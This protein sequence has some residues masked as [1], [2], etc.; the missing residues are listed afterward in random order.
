MIDQLLSQAKIAILQGDRA[1]ARIALRNAILKSPQDAQAW[2]LMAQVVE[3]RI[4]VVDCLQR[5]TQFDPDNQAAATALKVLMHKP[6]PTE[7][8]S[9]RLVP[10]I[11]DITVSEPI[12]LPAQT[13]DSLKRRTSINWSLVI[14]SV[15][16]FLVLVVS[17]LGPKIA[18]GDPLEENVILKFG[19]V[20][21][22]PPIPPFTYKEFPFG[23]DQ[24]GRDLYSRILWAVQPTIT[25][26]SA[27]ALVRL[28]LGTL[29]GL[30]AGW[31]RGLVGN[32]LDTAITAALAIP[33]FLV[34][35][36]AIAMLGAEMGL[37]AFIIGFSING[38][39]ETAR[40]VR[41]QTQAIKQQLYVE[42]AESIGASQIQILFSHVL[43]QI[44]PMVW[45]LLA[46]E[47]SNTLMVT[48]GLG[49]LGYYIGG[50]VWI[51]VGDFVSRRVS[52]MPELGQMLAT[53]WT[54]LTKPWPMVITGTIIFITVLGFN[55]FGEGL[56]L[57]LNPERGTSKRRFSIL[58][59]R[60]SWWLEEQAIR[61]FNLWARDNV[62]FLT[63]IVSL[64][65]LICGSFYLWRTQFSSNTVV[66]DDVIVVPG[67]H[68]WGSE[69]GD[70][71]GTYW[72]GSPGPTHP[73]VQW[74]LQM[75][76]GF[77]GGPVVAADH[78]IYIG[79]NNGHLLALNP[80]GS[81]LWD[82]SLPDIPVGSP[83]LS[84]GGVVYIGNQTGGLMA[85][86]PQG[87]LLW[88][89]KQDEVGKPLH[90][91]IVDQVGN[92]YYL[93]DDPRG[94]HLL[95]LTPDGELRWSIQ[96]GT[97]SA[98]AG[99]RLDPAGDVIYLKNVIF[100]SS[101]GSLI[102]IET[103]ADQDPV[104]ANRTQY[105]IGAD[106]EDYL[107]VGH[108]VINWQLTQSGFEVIESAEW[109][110]Q[111]AGFNQFSSFPQ[112]AG[113]TLDR[114]VWLFYSNRYGGTK[115]VWVD[116]SG[117][118]LGISWTS[119][120][121]NSRLIAIDS[122]NTAYI[123]GK[124]E[125]AEESAHSITKCLAFDQAGEEP[126]WELILNEQD[127]NDVIGAA[128]VPDTLYVVT[129]GGF[130]YSIEQDNGEPGGEN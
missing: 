116:V 48:A 59:H 36:G 57:Y 76:D 97:R 32:W 109:N 91:P 63:V 2:F 96:T 66:P 54:F 34:T 56:Q 28:L 74:Q 113:V 93:L 62:K 79:V 19:D 30:S 99:P 77:S 15:I 90:G 71:Y 115:M 95:S 10:P 105:F 9:I 87:E 89:F 5:V 94:D 35:L 67:D 127:G 43:R 13:Q 29:I 108:I 130:L 14:G 75:P 40:I 50:D 51:E 45:I 18:P 101:D 58:R 72:P 38:W 4:Q 119:L 129:E 52:G 126:K 98:D 81:T 7:K 86:D 12:E 123:C 22:T 112:D 47:I 111:T 25:M 70:P 88:H 17:I 24:F 73:R 85:I 68:L 128:L 78:T 102:D 37:M 65:V 100:D 44:M 6:A 61:P 82:I 42:A 20:W 49:F 83:A 64:F 84:N 121:R 26:V 46:F 103:P 106:G 117:K 118:M 3:E 110:Y 21:D 107:H 114:I 41:M 104:L 69:R 53:T 55:L 33:V 11:S 16:V 27:V 124:Q 23:T 60:L 80:D 120:R 1:T 8:A 125:T 122:S 31:S 92:I 39:G